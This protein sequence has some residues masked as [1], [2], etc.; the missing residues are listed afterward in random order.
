MALFEQ[1]MMAKSRA[2]KLFVRRVFI[3]DEFDES[4]AA[5]PHFVR[6]VVDSSDLPANVSR[7]APAESASSNHSQAFDSQD[8][9][10]AS[11]DRRA[12]Q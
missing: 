11:R 1:D 3:S 6:G 9:R 12:R 4:L 7:E 8:V 5:V 10:H 2:I